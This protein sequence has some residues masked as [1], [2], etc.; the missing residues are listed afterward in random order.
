MPW[1]GWDLS[2][3]LARERVA[4][5]ATA[6]LMIR[7][8][9]GLAAW[10]LFNE[11]FLGS[12][13]VTWWAVPASFIVY[14]TLNLAVT[15]YY[16]RGRVSTPLL[17]VDVLTNVAPLTL[18]LAA[19]G[20][21]ASPLL[22]LFPVKAIIYV[23]LFNAR[24]AWLSLFASVGML[25]LVVALGRADLVP[26][27]RLYEV[28][29]VA[30]YGA[31]RLAL[32]CQLAIAPLAVAWLR[33]VVAAAER[34]AQNARLER[35]EKDSAALAV[36]NT[37]L[38]AS[39]TLNPL[40]RVD[41]VLEQIALLAPRSLVA[42][43][44]AIALWF[45]GSG[46]YQLI[47]PGEDR[48]PLAPAPEDV[49]DFEWV[50]RLGHCVVVSA[51]E[52]SE[53]ADAPPA[54]L[55]APLLNGERF[56]G[57]LCLTRWDPRRVFTQR[58][59]LIAGGLARHA[60]IALDQ[61]RLFEE[62]ER[63]AQAVES[64]EEVIVITDARRRVLFANDAFLRTFGY[65]RHEII[66]R[67]ALE[68]AGHDAEWVVA[69]QREVSR[70]GW[71]AEVTGHRKDGGTMPLK[72]HC[73]AIRGDDGRIIGVVAFVQ[74][75]SAEKSF[76]EQLQRADRLAAVGEIAAGIAHEINNAL[77]AIFGQLEG[78]DQLEGPE[79]R[80][81]L[82]R[83]DRQAHRIADIVQGIVGFA[84]PRPPH[85]E[86]VDLAAITRET[87]D[88]L[89]RDLQ[90]VE[91]ET[92]FDADLPPA[93]ADRQQVQQ[94]LLNLLNNAL[95]AMAG[96]RPMRLR[97]AAA[98]ADDRLVIRVTDNGSGIAPEVLP[99]V[100]DPFFSTKPEGTGLGLSVSYAI[101]RAHGGE[102]AADSEPGKGTTFSLY[103]PIAP[104]PAREA[105][106]PALLVDDD[107]EVGQALADMLS[108]EGFVVEHASSAKEAL[109]K[110]DHKPWDVIL[111]DVRLPDR[112]GPEIFA[113][114]ARTRAHLAE[115]VVFVTGGVWRSE[116]R[117]RDELPAQPVLAK[118]CTQSQLRAILRELR[119]RGRAAA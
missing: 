111:L 21:L 115:R 19:S 99:R 107:P 50:R 106:R 104:Q 45:E 110:V 82:K 9:E 24:V 103:L 84:R 38:A 32:L 81:A 43:E 101:A 113:E 119:S 55:L 14:L 105:A 35:R 102:L 88:L 90:S 26:V 30:V 29:S 112:S 6:L 34:E 44:C 42:D 3:G 8:L 117:L 47:R 13:P 96:R 97:V 93:L 15:L 41:D 72:I 94:V 57:V 62:Y 5:A 86:P 51:P 91:L 114:L 52:G 64:T 60:A 22:L 118:P 49:K 53:P 80:A 92:D 54:L 78:V 67:D 48:R 63:L 77:T 37:V 85:P 28:P 7:V 74:D 1:G 69:A 108:K 59:L 66:G 12:A 109:A 4:H 116:S 65:E 73:N 79:L 18:P 11:F 83:I 76:H 39:E 20:G 33:R 23:T 10:L 98:G 87:L 46:Q 31:V 71:R 27:V 17:L 70:G 75:V 2:A 61:A 40:R 58:D 95:Q 16:R 68:L 100:F 56:N 36:A 25:A 89:R